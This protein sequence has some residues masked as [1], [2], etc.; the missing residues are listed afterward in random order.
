MLVTD[1][2]ADPNCLRGKYWDLIKLDFIE[3]LEH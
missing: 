3:L 1:I 2:N